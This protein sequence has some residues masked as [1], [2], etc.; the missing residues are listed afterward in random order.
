MDEKIKTKKMIKVKGLPLVLCCQVEISVET[1]IHEPEHDHVTPELGTHGDDDDVHPAF[2]IL[3]Q[4][5]KLSVFNTNRET[6]ISMK[7]NKWVS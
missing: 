6:F 3:T 4:S 1:R 2:R 5:E 7:E